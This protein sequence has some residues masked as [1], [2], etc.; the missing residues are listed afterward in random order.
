MIYIR[1]F[2]VCL[3]ILGIMPYLYGAL[4]NKCFGTHKKTYQLIY[5]G[6]IQIF[7][8]FGICAIP[9]TVMGLPFHKMAD[10][11][12]GIYL[13]VSI[14]SVIVLRNDICKI[15]RNKAA[16]IEDN[17]KKFMLLMIFLVIITVCF[18]QPEIND[19]TAS[20]AGT[21]IQTDQ[22]YQ[23]NAYTKKE[24]INTNWQER[25]APIEMFFGC[26]SYYSK[27]PVTVIVYVI[28]PAFMIPVLFCGY[29]SWAYF[30]YG[31]DKETMWKFIC[32][33]AAILAVPLFSKYMTGY[34]A[35]Q[36]IWQGKCILMTFILPMMIL[37]ILENTEDISKKQKLGNLILIFYYMVAAET[38]YY[39]GI[40][41]AILVTAAGVVLFWIR[42]CNRCSHLLK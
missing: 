42:R 14:A 28:F 17:D 22:M 19:S 18:V 3:F 8:L 11:L 39:S 4:W 20:I 37:D 34:D 21:A 36:N 5:N 7:A 15:F 40:I 35:F 25:L 10:I 30:F 1:G 29:Y 12:C 23:Y 33:C 13:I 31:K 41:L 24:I 38:V 6:Y 9:S 26:I 16:G 27:I 2:I 32:V